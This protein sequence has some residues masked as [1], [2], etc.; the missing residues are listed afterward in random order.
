MIPNLC[1]KYWHHSLIRCQAVVTD[2]DVNKDDN[3]KNWNHQ[4]SLPFT[5]LAPPWGGVC[6]VVLNGS[7]CHRAVN[8]VSRGFDC[9]LERWVKIQ[10]STAKIDEQVM[11]ESMWTAGRLIPGHLRWSDQRSP[12]LET[13]CESWKCPAV[14]TLTVCCN[15]QVSLQPRP[16]VPECPHT[17]GHIVFDRLSWTMKLRGTLRDN[18]TISRAEER[19]TAKVSMCG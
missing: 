19:L 16:E 5:S 15:I 18:I 13:N 6:V 1:A 10:T 4:E 2:P 9:R 7:L 3:R 12:C 14:R 11:A 8:I 17:Y